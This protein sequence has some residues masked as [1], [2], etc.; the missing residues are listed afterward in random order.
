MDAFEGQTEPILV[1]W[2]VEG[3]GNPFDFADDEAKAKYEVEVIK[4]ASQNKRRIVEI[5]SK[6]NSEIQDI[7]KLVPGMS[8]LNKRE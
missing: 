3:S 4:A 1:K 6:Q 8:T 2:A 5:K 7:N